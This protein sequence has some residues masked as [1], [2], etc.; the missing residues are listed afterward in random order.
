MMDRI[1]KYNVFE[2]NKIYL[3]PEAP[4]DR[5]VPKNFQHTSF[6]YCLLFSILRIIKNL[7][8]CIVVP[9]LEYK[10]ARWE[11][12]SHFYDK[13][14]LFRLPTLNNK[15]SLL[16]V[17][18][19]IKKERLNVK[20]VEKELE[21]DTYPLLR[22]GLVSLSKLPVFWR[23]YYSLQHRER[24]IVNYFM[25]DF[26]YTPG[27]VWFYNKMLNKYKPECV[28]LAN[29]HSFPTKPL[30]LLCENYG[31]P[32]VYVQHASVSDAFPELHFSH[33]FLDGLD[34]LQKYCSKDK[35]SK[36]FIFLLGAARFDDLGKYRK[37]RD[38]HMRKCLGICVNRLD[39]NTIVDEVC[40]AFLQHFPE[41]HIKVR[42]HPSMKSSPFTFTNKDK[43]IYTCATDETMIEYLDSIDLQVANDSSVHLDAILGGV[44]TI[45]Y[46]FSMNSYG[47]NYGY[48]K[49]KLLLL[50]ENVKQLCD[51]IGDGNLPLIDRS[52]VRYY[53]ESYEKKYSGN[54]SEIIA[55]FIINGLKVDNLFANYNIEKKSIGECDYYIFNE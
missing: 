23:G 28:V 55:D 53:D 19:K 4:F 13:T 1:N 32:C 54:I 36:G 48:V 16:K 6:L 42:M 35:H 27:V 7:L 40:V 29:D 45:A 2:I 21:Y 5:L 26:I 14:I 50:A 12:Y 25:A 24:R 20:I 41:W 52:K 46:N 17:I 31:V 49:N 51:Y 18:E 11:K 10:F 33:S 9:P 44:H 15:R 37:S 8:I 43:I 38:N 47:D 34:A 22:M 3:E 30:E 39:D